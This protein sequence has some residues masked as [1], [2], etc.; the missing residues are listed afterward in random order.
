VGNTNDL[1]DIF[2]PTPP[3]HNFDLKY[4]CKHCGQEYWLATF[5]FAVFLYGVFFLLGKKSIYI[6]IVCPQC[7]KTIL[8]ESDKIIFDDIKETLSSSKIYIGNTANPLYL[9]YHSSAYSFIRDNQILQDFDIV[10]FEDT[11]LDG[12]SKKDIEDLEAGMFSYL[13]DTS[14]ISEEYLCS[15]IPKWKPYVGWFFNVCWYREEQ[16]PDLV[17]IENRERLRIFPR[18]I[19]ED[20]TI[21]KIESFCWKYKFQEMFYQNQFNLRIDREEDFSITTDL[22]N[23]LANS[24]WFG[25]ADGSLFKT[26]K[27]FF[28]REV[29]KTLENYDINSFI[30]PQE[31]PSHYEMVRKVRSYFHKEYIQDLLSK[32]PDEFISEY[33]QSIQSID[34]SDASV[35]YL[36]EKY[37][38]ELYDSIL[39]QYQ[40]TQ[41]N[42]RY[43]KIDRQKVEEIEKEYPSFKKIISEDNQID[44]IKKR[45]YRRAQYKNRDKL[46]FLL[47]GETGTGKELFARAIGEAS[48]KKRPFVAFS[49]ETIPETMFP[50]E[51]FGHERGAFTDAKD[52]RKGLFEQANGGT[53]F[54]D[55]I[56]ELKSDLQTSLLRVIE[57][58]EIRRL[59]STQPI[60]IDVIIVLATNKNLREEVEKGNFRRDLYMRIKR[61]EEEIPE[62]KERKNDVS[63]LVKHFIRVYAEVYGKPEL[64]HI[65]VTDDCMK[66][67]KKYEWPG[68]I[69]D[70]ENV[71]AEIMENRVADNDTNDINP[72]DLPKEI[73]E[74]T[75][76]K[77]SSLS[78]RKGRKKRPSNEDLIRLKQEGWTQDKVAETYGVWR[79][80]VTRWYA[81]IEKEYKQ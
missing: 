46:A 35:W 65:G 30:A 39:S 78:P 29:P 21:D 27:P 48:G 51:L 66:L 55:E 69:R 37:L 80:T 71:I 32:M 44:N 13:E 8:I 2:G 18:Y 28:E 58:R 25:L 20:F 77:K 57:E 1:D 5:K 34:F 14:S 70:I 50:S 52:D 31:G 42:K 64:A 53:I 74:I 54:I 76:S 81:T 24:P 47:I 4:K 72:S 15:Y 61:F 41:T 19:S 59:G 67:F 49:C 60:R 10:C 43:V 6:G 63:F 68:N 33:I 36:R 73:F 23:I 38:K 56:G 11:G 16:I 26:K 17:K 62:L 45:L 3:E 79:E 40:R 9:Q 12:C 7:L 75:G 22:M